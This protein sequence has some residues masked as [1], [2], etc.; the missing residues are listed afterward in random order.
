MSLAGN[1]PENRNSGRHVISNNIKHFKGN[2]KNT[3]M[4]TL[5]GLGF[6]QI[7]SK[8]H[9]FGNHYFTSK[10]L[11]F[12]TFFECSYIKNNKGY[13]FKSYFKNI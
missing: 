13:S 6:S 5:G 9:S 12:L 1:V 8:Y 7:L 11:F 10:G 3:L 4:K 2:K